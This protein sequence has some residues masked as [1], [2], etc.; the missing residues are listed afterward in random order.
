MG[1]LDAGSPNRKR[2]FLILAQ[3]SNFSINDQAS[4]CHS[5]LQ[6]L[7]DEAILMMSF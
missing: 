4:F 5:P 2:L 6:R 1:I 7:V 3:Y